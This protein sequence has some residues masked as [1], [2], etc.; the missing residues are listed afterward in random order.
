VRS[1]I[2][3]EHMGTPVCLPSRTGTHIVGSADKDVIIE[4]EDKL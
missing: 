1:R 2:S 3:A 4:T